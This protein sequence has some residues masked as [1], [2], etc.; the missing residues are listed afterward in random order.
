MASAIRGRRRPSHEVHVAMKSRINDTNVTQKPVIHK[1][2]P[3][4]RETK[5]KERPRPPY[6]ARERQRR[7]A[8][9]QGGPDVLDV[10]Y[11]ARR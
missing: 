11:Y 6:L 5:R 8:A 3:P 2:N 9:G 7:E 4:Y 10:L 1:F